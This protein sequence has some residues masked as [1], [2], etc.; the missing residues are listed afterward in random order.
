VSD[1][2]RAGGAAYAATAAVSAVMNDAAGIDFIMCILVLLLTF[3]CCEFKVVD[4]VQSSKS[5]RRR[6]V[7]VRSGSP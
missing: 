3:D 2:L 5:I 4:F 1:P 7:S 6:L